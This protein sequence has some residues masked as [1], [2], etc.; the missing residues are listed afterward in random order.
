MISIS[1]PQAEQS[2][3]EMLRL[4]NYP[5]SRWRDKLVIRQAG[6]KSFDLQAKDQEEKIKYGLYIHEVLARIEYRDE[7]EKALCRAVM[8]GIITTAD[9]HTVT[10]ELNQLFTSATIASWFDRTWEVR[11]EVPILQPGGKENRIDRLLTKGHEA[12]L[13]DFKTGMPSRA[14]HEQV[15]TYMNILKQMNFTE[16]NGYVLYV[17]TGEVVEVKNGKGRGTKKRDKG[18][19]GLGI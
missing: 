11:T 7:L 9:K 10:H 18:Q 6:K 3:Q 4:S 2:E 8:D 14:D 17:R 13:I 5:V 1:E 19:L 16:V 12:V 15:L